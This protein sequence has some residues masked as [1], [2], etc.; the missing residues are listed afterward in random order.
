MYIMCI[1]CLWKPEEAVKPPGTGVTVMSSH[2]GSGI[3]PGSLARA[4]SPLT[5]E[6]SLQP[7]DYG[8]L[9][10]LLSVRDL[11]QI[12]FLSSVIMLV[13]Q[14]KGLKLTRVISLSNILLLP[15]NGDEIMFDETQPPLFMLLTM[16]L[17]G[18]KP[19]ESGPVSKQGRRKCA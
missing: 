13:L 1:Q 7:R 15:R 2:P 6:P 4:V 12:M 17:H 16:I 11:R 19:C 9:E 5:A 8:I 14:M 18:P 10:C 3:Q